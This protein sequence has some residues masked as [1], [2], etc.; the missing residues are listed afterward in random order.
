MAEEISKT[1]NQEKPT[2]GQPE[3]TFTQAEM[4]AII[5]ERLS[6]ERAKYADYEDIKAKAAKYDEAEEASKSELQKANEKASA[7][8]AK[9]DAMTKAE[10]I[11]EIRE[12]V[13]E[14]TGVPASILSGEDEESCRQQAEAI[15]KFARPDAYPSVKDGGEVHH[16]PEKKTRDQFADWFSKTLNK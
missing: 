15:L 7:L 8:Q 1:V 3:R 4:D 9:V 16:L 12:Q 5:G 6:R 13:S 11:R 2:A 14:K 10:K